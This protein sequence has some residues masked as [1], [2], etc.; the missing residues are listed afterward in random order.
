MAEVM[1]GCR[2]WFDEEWRDLTL[3]QYSWAKQVMV[4]EMGRACSMHVREKNAG[5]N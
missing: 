5:F 1:G 2:T 4:R 3:R